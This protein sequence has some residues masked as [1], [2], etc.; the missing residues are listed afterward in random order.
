MAL[1]LPGSPIFLSHLGCIAVSRRL[2]VADGQLDGLA[3]EVAGDT[4]DLQYRLLVNN[5]GIMKLARLAEVDDV[6]FEQIVAISLRG[7]FNGLRE[8]VQRL[9]PMRGG[10]ARLRKIRK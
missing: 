9:R 1:P 10:I 6:T 4:D 2:A 8:A 5:V 3:V 7:I